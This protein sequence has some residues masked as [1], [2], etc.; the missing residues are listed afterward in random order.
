MILATPLE[1]FAVPIGVEP[2]LNVTVPVTVPEIVAVKVTDWNATEGLT[3]DVR[4]TV[5]V[6]LLTVSF[7][8]GDVAELLIES[9]GVLAVIGSVPTGRLDTVIVATPPEIGAVPIGVPPFENVTGPETP[10]GTVSEI[11]TV[12]P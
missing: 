1:T 6:P 10:L 11:V 9:P 12:C 5:G 8:A 3:D 4:L 7:V 2:S